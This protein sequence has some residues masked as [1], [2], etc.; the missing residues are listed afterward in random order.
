MVSA[1]RSPGSERQVSYGHSG[2]AHLYGEHGDVCEVP[3]CATILVGYNP[4]DRCFRCGGGKK[5][6]RRQNGG[7]STSAAGEAGT[8]AAPASRHTLGE[9]IDMAAETRRKNGAARQAVIAFMA[10]GAWRGSTEVASGVGITVAA[11]KY[12]LQHLTENGRLESAGKGGRGYRQRQ[13]AAIEAA[14]AAIDSRPDRIQAIKKDVPANA[15]EIV[16]TKAD[17]QM[18][19]EVLACLPSVTPGMRTDGP[20]EDATIAPALPTGAAA[21]TPPPQQPADVAAADSPMV[22]PLPAAGIVPFAG[23]VM[24]SLVGYSKSVELRILDELE[25][26][27]DAG[28]ERVL[29]YAVDR[30]WLKA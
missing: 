18:A 19:A 5:R 26:L 29:Q 11:A 20:A 28:R 17:S 27:D 12:H 16:D 8:N 1:P 23:I 21:G 22:E 10:D 14:A 3:G 9:R 7:A 6:P 13:D 15:A 25:G 24:T 2:S 30:W 4:R